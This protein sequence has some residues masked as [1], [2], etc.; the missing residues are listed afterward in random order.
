MSTL[1]SLEHPQSNFQ[2]LLRMSRFIGHVRWTALLACALVVAWVCV[3]VNIMRL[4]GNITT[5]VQQ[6][7]AAGESLPTGISF[8]QALH[9]SPLDRIVLMIVKLGVLVILGGIIRYGREYSNAKYA[10]DI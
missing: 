10:M 2:L 6:I 5:L 8:W 3:D 7:L 1:S 9:E 4:T